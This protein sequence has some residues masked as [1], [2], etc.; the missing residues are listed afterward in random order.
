MKSE[1]LEAEINYIKDERLKNNLIKIIDM[2]PNYIFTIPAAS[3]GKYHPASSLGEGGLVR[4]IK[5]ATR[6]AYELLNNESLNNF[7]EHEKD[8]IY[9]SIIL[10]DGLKCGMTQEKYTRFDHPILM[11]NFIKD[12]K[13]KL[14]FIDEE[15]DYITRCIETHM[16]PWTKDFNGNEILRKPASKEERFVHMCD[17]LSSK[18]FL[19]IKFVNNEIDTIM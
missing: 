11:S 13:D 12:S 17:Y 2:L 6:I 15:I 19:D 14:T 7:S 3:T 18:R 9:I 5:T 10:H 8:L 1:I 16:G 4:H